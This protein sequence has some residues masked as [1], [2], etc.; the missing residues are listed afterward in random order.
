MTAKQL[1]WSLA[2]I[3]VAAFVNAVVGEWYAQNK[4]NS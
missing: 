4:R 3:T 1:G 2:L